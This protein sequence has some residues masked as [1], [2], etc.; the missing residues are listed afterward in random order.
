MFQYARRGLAALLLTVSVA[1]VAQLCRATDP[2]PVVPAIDTSSDKMYS[3]SLGGGELT[4][5]KVTV[6]KVTVK[7]ADG[8][9]VEQEVKEVMKLYSRKKEKY[10]VA[11]FV[12]GT[13]GDDTMIIA[14]SEK[15]IYGLDAAEGDIMWGVK[16]GLADEL[17]TAEIA[18]D[19]NVVKVTVDGS[20]YRLDAK[21][22][23]TVE[24]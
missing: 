17:K 3:L 14:V 4:V 8:Q 13:K 5:G 12:P 20:V 21:T 16:P 22:G 23:K 15:L 18:F 6:K 9:S 7:T 1:S 11:K 10:L 2:P 24:D 19:G